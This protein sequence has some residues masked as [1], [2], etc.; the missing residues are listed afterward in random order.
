MALFDDAKFLLSYMKQSFIKEDDTGNSER[1]LLDE[2]A[3]QI[4]NLFDEPDHHILNG[5]CMT[6]FNLTFVS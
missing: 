3:G 4:I 5:E 6:P 2:S 1:S